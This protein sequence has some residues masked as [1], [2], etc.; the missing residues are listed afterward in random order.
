M[1]EIIW[2]TAKYL[3][4]SYTDDKS[5]ES[6]SVSNQ[7]KILDSY[8]AGQPDM[9]SVGEWVDDG[10]TGLVFDRPAF[11]EM[12]D[13]IEKGEINCVVVKDLSRFGREYTETGRYIRR[14]LPSY[15]VRLIALGDSI[16]TL[17]DRG[18]DLVVSVKSMLNDSYCRDI[19][20][21][22]RSALR[23]KRE[24]GD[25]VGACPVYGYRK[26]PNDRNHL[27]ID[28]YPSQ[29]VRDIFRMK[30]EG[31]SALKIADE[32]NRLGVLSPSEYKKDRELPHPKGGYADKSGAL[33]SA[34]TIIRILNDE[35]YTG[36]L[37]QGRQGTP[38]YKLKEV[39]QRPEEDWVRTQ[40]AHD[41]IIS[42]QD[43]DLAQRIM[44]LDTR[45]APNGGS[46]YLFSGILICGCCG[47]RMTRKAVPYKGKKYHYYYCPT[48]KK[49]GCIAA[50]M[51]KETDLA[52][53][54]LDS[55][56][57]H[58]TNVASLEDIIAAS[59]SQKAARALAN[60]FTAQIEDNERQ[61]GKIGDI[62]RTL[63]ENLVSG[64]IDQTDY[65]A[66]KN[67]YAADEAQKRDAIETLSVKME[68]VLAGKGD[69]LR[70]MESFKQFSDLQELDRRTVISLIQSI[71]VVSKTELH[72]TFHYQDEYQTVLRLIRGEVAA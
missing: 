59:D 18:D 21:K 49:R 65:K 58:V 41:A 5:T 42:P 38:N 48:T 51:L 26:D 6:D 9:E 70:W 28:E 4:K 33:W 69:R 11:K 7:R 39:S 67:K 12:M 24:G 43:F 34:T 2:K 27:V 3:R 23:V 46:V 63:Y 72:I 66:L 32:L 36:A 40:D 56:K 47:A 71:R 1:S 55:V 13:A 17:K 52:E 57:A 37:V 31:I 16:D 54:I 29:I 50:A 44:R 64:L 25:Y 10:V 62:K 19:S 35:T 8:I 14:I 30:I 61:L 68:E 22:T 15:G 60:Q 45:T 53:C 20:V